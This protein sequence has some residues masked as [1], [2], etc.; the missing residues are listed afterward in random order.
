[1]EYNRLLNTPQI[2]QYEQFK[3]LRGYCFQARL[4]SKVTI[5]LSAF[6][7]HAFWN[8]SETS[9]VNELSHILAGR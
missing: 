2:C 7:M 1:M 4:L 5:S 6:T 8:R 9:Q 3:K